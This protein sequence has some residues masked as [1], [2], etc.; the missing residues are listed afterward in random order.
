M[1]THIFIIL[2]LVNLTHQNQDF[3][4]TSKTDN[5]TSLTLKDPAPPSVSKHASFENPEPLFALPPPEEFNYPEEVSQLSAVFRVEVPANQSTTFNY[6]I[7]ENTT[8]CSM[9]FEFYLSETKSPSEL[10]HTANVKVYNPHNLL[11]DTF[12]YS[13]DSKRS[14]QHKLSLDTVGKYKFVLKNK[15]LVDVIVDLVFGLTECHYLKHKLHRNDF[16]TF[17]NRFNTGVIR[18]SVC[19]LVCD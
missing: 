13:S 10:V 6:Q 9:L 11:I 12:N 17:S 15:N 2:I 14:K 19:L 1:K 8:N 18:Q 3:T 5:S 4:I 7:K 16:V